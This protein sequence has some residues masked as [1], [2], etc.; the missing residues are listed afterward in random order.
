MSAVNL[1]PENWSKITRGCAEIISEQEL[2]AKLEKGRPLKI[3]L[4]VDPTA[5]DLHL[6]HLVVLR[7]LRAFQD[8]GHQIEFIIGDFTARIGDPSGRSE[9]R[10]ALEPEQ[11]AANAQ[12]YQEQ[13]FRVLDHQKT[14]LHFNSRWLEPLGVKGIFDLQR[15]TSVAQML[16]RA[17]FA[18]RFED[19]EPISLLE[20]VYPVLQGYDSIA[21]QADLELGGTD[22]KFN[23]LMGRELQLEK[24]Q[25][26]QVVMMMPLL[27]GLDG[28]KKMSKSY[29][30]TVAFND[31]PN[32]MFG[33]TM[34]IPDALMPK[35][36]ELL[37][38]LDV[39]TAAKMHP[40]EAKAL[41][42]KTI[43]EMFH[44]AP[45]AE[46]AAAEFD[47]V[48]SKKQ[49]PDQIPEFKTVRGKC[50]LIDL[51]AVSGLASSKK[52][53]RRL[54]DQGAVEVDGKRRTEKDT[55]DLQVPVL[56]Q[57]GKRRFM[58]VIPT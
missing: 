37:T 9:T 2:R 3:K 33:K 44:G 34:S 26:P 41:L 32:E 21:I 40:R 30:N 38:D 20:L 56:I 12:T 19:E 31:P 4:G 47:R 27:E 28:V 15:R 39:A 52:E 45:A 29:G 7:K 43:V 24:G 54:L 49:V 48:F 50:L 14:Q 51:L 58:R 5:P 36:F 22:Q 42:G 18:K 13:V 46:A 16:R 10:P 1:S 6:G 35:Y 23:L 57:V 53:A 25:E 8:L 55:L 11:V 17:D